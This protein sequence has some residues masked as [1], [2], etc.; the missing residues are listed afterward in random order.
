MPRR[1]TLTAEQIELVAQFGN[2]AFGKLGLTF[3]QVAEKIV[4]A[5]PFANTSIGREFCR[6]AKLAFDRERPQLD[7][8]RLEWKRQRLAESSINNRR[9]S[10]K[11]PVM[12]DG[13]RNRSRRHR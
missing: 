5:L 11:A 13:S 12:Q 4:G 3:D 2:G 1:P 10:Q 8:A 9:T 7:L 6:Q